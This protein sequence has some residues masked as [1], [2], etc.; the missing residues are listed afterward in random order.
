MK[1]FFTDDFPIKGVKFIDILQMLNTFRDK[2]SLAD[3]IPDGDYTIILPETL[4][5]IFYQ[6]KYHHIFLRKNKNKIP[7]LVETFSYKNEYSEGSFSYRKDYLNKAPKNA[8]IIDDVLATGH[9]ALSIQKH[10]NTQTDL[11]VIGIV[12]Y[13]ELVDLNGRKL[14][15]SNGLIARSLHKVSS[16]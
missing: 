16:Y 14:L 5:Y 10:F 8:I 4:G 6:D 15:E 11:N 1:E 2:D 12:S 13:V 3:L 9:T 7:G